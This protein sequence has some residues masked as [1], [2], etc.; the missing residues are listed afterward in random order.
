MSA[1]EKTCILNL[2]AALEIAVN[3]LKICERNKISDDIAPEALKKIETIMDI[4]LMN[5][6]LANQNAHQPTTSEDAVRDAGWQSVENAPRDIDIMTLGDFLP[7]HSNEF[8]EITCNPD[9][10]FSKT[11][12]PYTRAQH[13]H[14][15]MN[16][17]Y[18]RR[19]FHKLPVPPDMKGDHT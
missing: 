11:P 13:Q 6:A 16:G 5:L 8:I 10:I 4:G 9:Q 2:K 18:T 3:A 1:V 14:D 7:S 12:Y 17:T 15:G 19:L